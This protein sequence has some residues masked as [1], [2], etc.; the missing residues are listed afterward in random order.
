MSTAPLP[1]LTV[2]FELLLE[3]FE[4]EAELDTPPHAASAAAA[5]RAQH[6]ALSVL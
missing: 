1:A 5:T 2:F 3:L 6:P 4:L